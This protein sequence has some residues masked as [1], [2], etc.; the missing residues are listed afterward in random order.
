MTGRKVP[1]ARSR[2]MAAIRGK[3]TIPEQTVRRALHARGIRYS[4]HLKNLPGR[5]DLVLRRW[6]AVVFV[7]GCF[8]HGHN[9]RYFRQPVTRAEFW[10]TKIRDNRRRDERAAKELRAQGW[11]VATVWECAIRSVDQTRID[12]LAFRLVR[13]L[14]HSKRNSIEVRGRS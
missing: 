2:N 12:A 5:P 6:K 14:R 3:D 8:W 13:W 7:H 9:C 1:A 10:T 4:M 11:R